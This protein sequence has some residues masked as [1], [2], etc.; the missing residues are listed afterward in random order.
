MNINNKGVEPTLNKIGI[1]HDN[2]QS[3]QDSTREKSHKIWR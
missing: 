2:V 3:T 1:L